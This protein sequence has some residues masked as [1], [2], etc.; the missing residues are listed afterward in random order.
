[1]RKRTLFAIPAPLL[2]AGALALAAQGL[3]HA[4]LP[5]PA[6]RAEDLP[7]PPP[8]AVLRAA[9]LGE[10]VALA[11]WL[12]LDLQAFDN[13]PGVSLPLAAL[14]Y[15]RVIAWL[16]A[17]L[18][19]DPRGQYPLLAASRLYGEVPDPAKQRRMIE[20]VLARFAEDPGRR[21]PWLAH[22]AVVA[23]HRLGD[24]VLARR[25]ATALRERATGPGVPD[26]VE[27]MDI[28]LAADMNELEAARAL[29]GGLLASGQVTDPAELRF[30]RGR[31][32]AL[33]RRQAR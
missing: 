19:L 5:A 11:K 6:A 25:C 26:W 1:M 24:L 16:D 23:R 33:E 32:E 21:W 14:D 28:L 31:L 10:P 29:L 18:A 17:I 27:Q 13:Q 12:M 20:F 3:L 7:A 15:G 9:S 30:L 2:V 22:A 8:A 4:R